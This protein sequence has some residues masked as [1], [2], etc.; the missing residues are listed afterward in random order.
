MRVSLLI[1]VDNEV[2]RPVK[3]HERE[4][5]CCSHASAMPHWLLC[6]SWAPPPE[7]AYTTIHGSDLNSYFGLLITSKTYTLAF[8]KCHISIVTQP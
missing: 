6:I 8:S 1:I 4:T 3:E 7:L 5:P 2:T